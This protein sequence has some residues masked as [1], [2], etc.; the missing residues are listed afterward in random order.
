MAYKTDPAKLRWV[1]NEPT[2]EWHL[3][4]SICQ[5]VF[6]VKPNGEVWG[7]E[8]A[9]ALHLQAGRLPGCFYRQERRRNPVYQLQVHP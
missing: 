4:Y 6:S 2:H 9:G 5:T 7:Q 8:H 1:W 3:Y